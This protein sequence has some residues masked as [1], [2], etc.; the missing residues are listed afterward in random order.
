MNTT[1]SPPMCHPTSMYKPPSTSSSG[2][3]DQ[4]LVNANNNLFPLASPPLQL[5][6]G[7]TDE[8]L[9][10][11]DNF[12]APARPPVKYGGP[13]TETVDQQ[14]QQQSRLNAAVYQQHANM[15]TSL[16]AVIVAI[17][18]I[19]LPLFKAFRIGGDRG[20]RGPRQ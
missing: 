18:F 4:L 13:T 6:S 3:V 14:Q 17:L 7:G 19:L 11:M 5:E 9:S 10:N 2:S 16:V 15:N 12:V 20:P 1:D 8:R